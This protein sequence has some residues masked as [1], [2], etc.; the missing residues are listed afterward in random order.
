MPT[1]GGNNRDPVTS[2]AQQQALYNQIQREIGQ[3][4]PLVAGDPQLSREFQDLITRAQ[5]LDPAKFGTMSAELEQRIESQ[6]LTELDQM[7]LLLRRKAEADGSVRS[8]SPGTVAPGY[9]NAVA[10]Y[11]R[12]L[13]KQ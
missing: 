13:S 12:K 4:R 11:N 6:A 8:V 10:E 2:P 7:E 1:S 9:A 3:L 5:G